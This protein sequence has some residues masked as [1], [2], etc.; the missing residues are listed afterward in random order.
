LSRFKRAPTIQTI[1]S[2]V[3]GFLIFGG[4]LGWLVYLL[5]EIYP[6]F[7]HIICVLLLPPFLCGLYVGL[8]FRQRIPK[9]LS[10]VFTM[11]LSI[12]YLILNLLLLMSKSGNIFYVIICCTFGGNLLFVGMIKLVNFIS[13]RLSLRKGESSFFSRN[14]YRFKE[15]KLFFATWVHFSIL[16]LFPLIT[17]IFWE[18][19]DAFYNILGV[20]ILSLGFSLFFFFYWQKSRDELYPPTPTE[21][22]KSKH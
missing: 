19:W 13:Y 2:F 4:S 15:G 20:Y 5:Y 3:F 22:F 8:F 12:L 1:L 16:Q 11:L 14:W 17:F 7:N 21:P 10:I 18:V 6:P 9:I